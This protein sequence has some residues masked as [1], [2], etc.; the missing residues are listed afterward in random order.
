MIFLFTG[1][2]SPHSLE[3][4]ASAAEDSWKMGEQVLPA[5]TVKNMLALC[6]HGILGNLSEDAGCAFEANPS[7]RTASWGLIATT[8]G[9]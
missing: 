8:F 4:D 6:G 1:Y 5:Q 2:Y 7:P 3:R 9:N